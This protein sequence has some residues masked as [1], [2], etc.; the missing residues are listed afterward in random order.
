[1]KVPTGLDAGL[2]QI[3]PDATPVKQQTLTVPEGAFG[4]VRAKQLSSLATGV[5]GIGSIIDAERR[6][7]QAEDAAAEARELTQRAQR[8]RA[9]EIAAEQAEE[10]FEN[11]LA[12]AA[13][14]MPAP[15]VAGAGDKY[16]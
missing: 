8:Q 5:Q 4:G 1:M 10:D 12:A 7:S 13:K 6:K 15:G 14:A 3:L 11:G 16:R 2:G 9:D